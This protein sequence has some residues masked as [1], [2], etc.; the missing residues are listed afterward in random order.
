MED[1]SREV[2][3]QQQIDPALLVPLLEMARD[4]LIVVDPEQDVLY[5]NQSACTILGCS[6]E[7]LLGHAWEI[8]LPSCPEQSSSH[9]LPQSDCRVFP[10]RRPDGEERE[11]E[12]IQH[13]LPINGHVLVATFLRDVTEERQLTR[14]ANALAQVATSL[15]YTDSLEATLHALARSVVQATGIVACGIVLIKKGRPFL[16]GTSGLPDGYIAGMQEVWQKRAQFSNVWV[17]RWNQML[18]IRD[19]RQTFLSNPT[20]APIHDYLHTVAWDTMVRLPLI[21]QGRPLGFLAGYSLPGPGPSEVDITFLTAVTEYAAIAVEHGRLLA[22]TQSK[23]TLEERQRLA[24]ELHDSVTQSLYSLTL[25]AEAG[26]RL[27]QAGDLERVQG[28]L[29]RLGETARQSLKEMRLLVYA[30]RPPVLEQDGL[31]GALQHRLETVE[32]RVGVQ[33]RLV[34]EEEGDVPIFLEEDL[35]RIALEA[36]NNTLKHAQA[37]AVTVHIR[38]NTAF[39]EIEIVDDGQGFDLETVQS[40]GGM[41]LVSMCERA[42][43]LGGSLTIL[44][45]AGHGTRIQVRVADHAPGRSTRSLKETQ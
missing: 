5:A 45:A 34:I 31:V 9:L 23:A 13:S 1:S 17:P 20:Y 12:F 22:E 16:T 18:I 25:L 38:V 35:Y 6:T 40:R 37:T 33:A 29:R 2:L 32:K 30:L 8:P 39:V 19:F 3:Y 43:R 10:L 14:R 24:R 7:H 15:A 26:R 11:I 44:S 27:A 36:L 21:Y 41:G 28:Y 42:Q 4:G